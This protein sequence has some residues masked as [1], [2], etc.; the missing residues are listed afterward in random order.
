MTSPNSFLRRSVRSSLLGSGSGNRELAFFLVSCCACSN[1]SNFSKSG[2]VLRVGWAA[3]D[4]FESCS[5]SVGVADPSSAV[6]DAALGITDEEED[7]DEEDDEDDEVAL[8]TDGAAASL[9]CLF[10]L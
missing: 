2:K 7:D 10:R 8:E 6:A 4:P 3:E 1:F 9:A 5:S